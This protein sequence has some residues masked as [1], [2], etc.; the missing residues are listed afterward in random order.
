[1]RTMVSGGTVDCPG[2][3]GR[4]GE[5]ILAHKL[6]LAHAFGAVRRRYLALIVG[7]SGGEGRQVA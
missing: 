3:L 4:D 7:A 1:M 6:I 2:F 5:G